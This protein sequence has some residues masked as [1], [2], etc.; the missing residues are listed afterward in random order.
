MEETSTHR[1]N[2]PRPNFV[3]NTQVEGIVEE[4]SDDNEAQFANNHPNEP[5][6]PGV[7]P[8]VPISS[9]LPPGET[10]ISW[11][12]R[13][14]GALNVVYTQLCAQVAPQ[15]QSRRPVSHARTPS[16]PHVSQHAGPSRVQIEDTEVYSRSPSRYEYTQSENCRREYRDE[17]HPY[18]RPSVHTR[19]RAVYNLEVE[20]NYDLIYRPAEAA[21]NSKFISEIALAPLE[22]E[23]LPSTVGKFNGMTD[24]DDHLR[25]FTSVGLVGGWTLP[26]WCHLFIQTL[27]GAARIW[28]Y[29]LPI[30]KI[31]S[32]IYLREKFLVHFSQQRRSIRDTADGMNIWRHDDESLED[33]ITRYNKEVLEIG[34]VHEQ[35]IRAQFNYAVR[36]DDMIKVL[37][38]TEGLPKSWEKV[39]AAAKV[40]AQTEKNL[41]TNRP[42]PPHNRPSD[43]GSSGGRKFKKGWRDSSSG[44][45]SSEDAR[46]TINK[47]T[48]QREAK[49]ENRER[50]WTPLTK[51]PAEVLSTEDYQF[52]PPPPMKNKCGQ[53]PSQYCE[54]HKDNGHTTNNCI[55]LPTEIE[56]AL[57]SGELTH[58]LQNV[59]KE[60]KQI[61]RGEEG[62]SKKAKN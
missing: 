45:Y 56:K 13:S 50:Q 28:F 19:P 52:K 9:I 4:A 38:G 21:E 8:E 2:G 57:K 34:D 43:L 39:M 40:Y 16:V 47:L 11:Y 33:F 41:T 51:T 36:S 59:R 35:L 58:L 18:R 31:T 42:P 15:T 7:Q 49:Q 3:N 46:A 48:A 26:M 61:T 30:G 23:K 20:H 5:I 55:S 24:P 44:N 14:Q 27:T 22:K 25:V 6:T 62:P 1:Q 60:I 37:S 17:S 32:W 54:Y 12:V 10:P 53:D 29:N